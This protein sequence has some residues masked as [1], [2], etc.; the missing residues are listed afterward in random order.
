VLRLPSA[1]GV[2]APLPLRSQKVSICSESQVPNLRYRVPHP[3]P[4]QRLSLPS[5]TIASSRAD[6]PKC[7]QARM[8]HP[9]K[10]TAPT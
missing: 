8:C 2:V 1:R 3:T 9:T 5:E 6:I 10:K 7:C 4:P